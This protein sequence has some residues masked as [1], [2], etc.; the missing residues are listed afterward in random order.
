MIHQ[1]SAHK[2]ASSAALAAVA[3][4]WLV[5]SSVAAIGDGLSD[6]TTLLDLTVAK[7]SGG[8]TETSDVQVPRVVDSNFAL[9]AWTTY[10]SGGEMVWSR[11]T[12][13]SA[14]KPIG[15][16]GGEAASST[17]ED[18]GV[19]RDTARIL[20]AGMANCPTHLRHTITSHYRTTVACLLGSSAPTP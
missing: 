5:A 16:R 4:I 17:L 13:Q 1:T 12:S 18:Y 20:V 10:E 19:P 6:A 8:M 7:M 11:K 14:W 3:V 9:S 2:F 15:G